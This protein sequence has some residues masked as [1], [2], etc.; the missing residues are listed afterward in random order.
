MV[1]FLYIEGEPGVFAL[2]SLLVLN[3]SGSGASAT[4]VIYTFASPLLDML[5][6]LKEKKM[7]QKVLVVFAVCIS[8]LPTCIVPVFGNY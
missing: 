6:L 3:A 8:M 5:K 1:L 2:L 4:L 7:I